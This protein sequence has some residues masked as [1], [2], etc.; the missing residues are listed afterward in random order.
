ML[1]TPAGISILVKLS[2]SENAKSPILFTPFGIIT[3]LSFPLYFF[4]TSFSISKSSIGDSF[5]VPFFLVL[6][7]SYTLLLSPKDKVYCLFPAAFTK[8]PG[9]VVSFVDFNKIMESL[10]FFSLSIKSIHLLHS[11]CTHLLLKYFSVLPM[12]NK[13]WLLNKALI[14]C[15]SSTISINFFGE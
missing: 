7:N 10:S 14:I 11:L 6:N 12:T 1:V 8:A 15:E 5:L 4:N 13:F 9:T 2:Q 3:S